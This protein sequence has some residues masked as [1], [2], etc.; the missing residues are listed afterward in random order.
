[1]T[2]QDVLPLMIQTAREHER[3]KHKTKTRPKSAAPHISRPDISASAAH[4]D[5][6]AYYDDQ[7]S[8]APVHATNMANA[9]AFC[10][11]TP[12]AKQDANPMRAMLHHAAVWPLSCVRR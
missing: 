11:F 8:F 5:A 12:I 6:P 9:Y 10:A 2:G 1:M 7:A 3:G 4:K